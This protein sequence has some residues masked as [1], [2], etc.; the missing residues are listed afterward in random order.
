MAA[1]SA[2][3]K[4]GPCD[5]CDGDHHADVCPHFRKERDKHRDAWAQYGKGGEAGDA[6]RRAGGRA[7]RNAAMNGEFA[8]W[9]KMLT[10]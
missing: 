7:T 5:K 3:P 9:M 10:R 6:G 4:A 2:A 8:R 1:A